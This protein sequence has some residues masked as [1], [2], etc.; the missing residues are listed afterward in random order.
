MSYFLKIISSSADCM[1]E[2]LMCEYYVCISVSE[3]AV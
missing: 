3:E 1:N 2:I